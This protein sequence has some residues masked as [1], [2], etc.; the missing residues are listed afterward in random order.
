MIRSSYV[1]I[2]SSYKKCQIYNRL[3]HTK[4]KKYQMSIIL[5]KITKIYEMFNNFFSPN[6]SNKFFIFFL[7]LTFSL[8]YLLFFSPLFS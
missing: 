5:S 1:K 6:C 7:P 4:I 2:I 3:Y 8:C